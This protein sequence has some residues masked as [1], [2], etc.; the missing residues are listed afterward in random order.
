MHLE[1]SIHQNLSQYYIFLILAKHILVFLHQD[2][3][4]IL[5]KLFSWKRDHLEH[6]CKVKHFIQIL[7]TIYIGEWFLIIKR[8]KFCKFFLL[9]TIFLKGY[10]SINV[11]EI[12]LPNK[13]GLFFASS[14]WTIFFNGRFTPSMFLQ[15]WHG[16]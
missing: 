13:L 5:R 7:S 1:T 8:P 16:M 12:F 9:F 15:Y 2:K 14:F 4:H 11:F 6:K 3:Q 10:F